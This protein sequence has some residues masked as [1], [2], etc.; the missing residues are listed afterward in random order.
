MVTLLEPREASFVETGPVVVEQEDKARYREWG[1]GVPFAGVKYY[2][3]Q[4]APPVSATVR[5]AVNAPRLIDE[6]VILL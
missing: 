6:R 2:T 3:F 1:Y 5:R 4:P